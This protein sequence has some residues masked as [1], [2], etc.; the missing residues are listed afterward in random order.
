MGLSGIF[1]AP[2]VGLKWYQEFFTGW[3]SWNIVR[4]TLYMSFAK[5]I[6]TYPLPILLALL[7][8]EIRVSGIKRV[9][10][11]ASYLPYF[12]SWVIVA[13]FS[14]IF[15]QSNGV[16]NSV[17]MNLGLIESTIAFQ[18]SAQYFLPTVVITAMWKDMGWWAILF[19]ASIA[20]I[21]PTLYEV[22][23]IDGAGRLR[24]IWHITLPG[25]R[26]T[27]I[28]LFILGIGGLLNTGFEYQLLIGTPLTREVHEV[29]DTYV[30]RYGVQ[31]GRYSFA[32]AVGL[33]KS[34]IGFTLVIVANWVAKKVSDISIL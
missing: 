1:T 2:W 12:I 27:V 22:A 21:D 33:M 28:L 6:F 17:M 20:G 18:T 8:N 34:V 23:N 14:Q 16:I 26:V 19:L 4:N 30:Y 11:T 13:G 24:R 7:L 3:N 31:Q 29:V 25:I 32:T 15:L 9:V 10:Q 5:L